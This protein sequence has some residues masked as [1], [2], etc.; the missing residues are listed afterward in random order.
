M[1]PCIGEPVSYLRLERYNLHEL[2]A[3][4]D[5][6]V[7]EHL[8][9]CATCRACFERLQADGRE[10]DLVALV[11]P[12]PRAAAR[13]RGWLWGAGAIAASLAGLLFVMHAEPG[14]Q[15]MGLVKGGDLALEL[16]RMDAQ[17]Q[18]LDPTRF[19]QGDRF[20][21]A[22]SCPP[23][24]AGRVRV[25][26]FQ[27]G[28]IFEPLPTQQ[29]ESCGNRRALA[30]AFQLDGSAPVELCVMLGEQGP[31]SARSRDALP[32]PHVCTRIEPVVA[33]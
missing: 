25:L 8:A 2:P 15:P 24:L 26:A 9:Q 30:G 11:A 14:L 28:E 6:R 17:G 18:L 23:A 21:I 10:Q 3:E 13:P 29:L 16:T 7:A 5:R 12:P 20:K 19:A 22:L 27:A 33:R 4:D 32:D 1:S 31:G